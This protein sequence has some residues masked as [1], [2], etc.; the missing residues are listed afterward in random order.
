MKLGRDEVLMDPYKC[1]CLSGRSAKGRI[2]GGVKICHGVPFFK[3]LLLQT[4]RLQRETECIAM[5]Y[6]HVGRSVVT[7]GSIPK[8]DF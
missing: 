8:S 3:K 5:I 2:Q 7:F 4:G 6:K 1:C